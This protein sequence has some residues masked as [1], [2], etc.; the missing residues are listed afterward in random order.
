MVAEHSKI[1]PCRMPV[2]KFIWLMESSQHCLVSYETVKYDLHIRQHS[3]QKHTA[4]AKTALC[5]VHY[6]EMC[7][8]FRLT[9]WLCNRIS[10]ADAPPL[11]RC[12][13]RII[14]L[15]T[16]QCQPHHPSNVTSDWFIALVIQIFK[17]TL[18]VF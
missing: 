4:Y 6:V 8:Q 16:S 14:Q 1:S 2:F 7:R 13:G 10:I 3:L 5:I 12:D 17:R 15:Q 11:A 9:L 18:C